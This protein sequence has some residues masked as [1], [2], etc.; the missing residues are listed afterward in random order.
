MTALARASRQAGDVSGVDISSKNDTAD[1]N[2]AKKGPLEG[3]AAV[4]V[5]CKQS[6]RSNATLLEGK[7][8]GRVKESEALQ[9]GLRSQPCVNGRKRFFSS[10]E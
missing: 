3:E 7:L 6:L 1:E 4:I 2:F 8:R 10:D 5:Q 9:C